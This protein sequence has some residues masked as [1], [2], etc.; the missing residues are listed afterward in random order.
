MDDR[1]KSPRGLGVSPDVAANASSVE[2]A[3]QAGRNMPP[4]RNLP[5]RK[6][7]RAAATIG[8]RP[9]RWCWWFVGLC[10]SLAMWA[11]IA[12]VFGLV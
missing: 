1:P 12:M 8:A 7:T 11:G 9:L 4:D 10:L 5:P 3:Y 2:A 6:A